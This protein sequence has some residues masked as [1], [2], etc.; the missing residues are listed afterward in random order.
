MDGL[1]SVVALAALNATTCSG[2]FLSLATV[3]TR[4]RGGQTAS[5]GPAAQPFDLLTGGHSHWNDM[6]RS[7]R[8]R[9]LQQSSKPAT[10]TDFGAGPG[11]VVGPVLALGYV[12]LRPVHVPDQVLLRRS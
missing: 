1:R 8:Q 9:D 7:L 11:G 4:H 12:V 6:V 5:A 10:G 2:R 3:N